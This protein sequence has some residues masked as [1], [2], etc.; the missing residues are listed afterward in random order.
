MDYFE[1]VQK[2]RARV[3]DAVNFL[4]QAGGPCYPMLFLKVGSGAWTPVG[5]EMLY[6]V[7]PDKSGTAAVVICDTEGNSKAMTAWVP[8]VKAEEQAQSLGSKGLAKF[9]GEV[10][11][12]I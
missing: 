10:R 9:E 6:A 1:A 11:L 7:V 4:Q 12:P 5:E 8:A 3:Q 2:G